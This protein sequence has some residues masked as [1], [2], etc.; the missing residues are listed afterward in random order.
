MRTKNIKLCIVAGVFFLI[1]AACWL[2]PD[3][4]FSESER[5]PLAQKPQISMENLLSGQLESDVEKYTA[6]QFPLR[7]GFR[8]LK[9]LAEYGLFMKKDNNDIYV[10]KGHAAKILYPYNPKSVANATDV[11]AMVYDE[12]LRGTKTDSEG[13][14]FTAIIPDKGYYLAEDA[15]IPSIDYGQMRAQI[16]KEMYYAKYIDITEALDEDSYY[17]TDLHWRQE[18]IIPAAQALGEAMDLEL[19]DMDNLRRVTGDEG[20]KGV[21]KGQSGLPLKAEPLYYLTNDTIESCSTFNYETNEKGKVYDVDKLS[22][23]DPYDVFLSGAAALITVENPKASKETDRELVVF[24]DSFGSSLLPL[25]I[26]DYAKITLVDLRYIN[27]S[28]LKQFVEFD[29]Q[30]ILFIYGTTLLNDSYTIK[31]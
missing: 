31:R 21:Y 18:K 17:R 16:I 28:Y 2:M 19:A 25:L 30:D 26:S 1:S 15:G 13:R 6:D 23:R 8:N 5:R 3:K 10:E 4:E 7:E 11:F 27:R 24:R 22:G 12:Y 29:N 14:I 20:F 9:A